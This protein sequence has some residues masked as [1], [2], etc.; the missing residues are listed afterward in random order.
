MAFPEFDPGKKKLLFFSRGRGRGHAIPDIEIVR[1]LAELR[2]DIDLRFVSYSTGART[3]E[4]AGYKLI[5]LA[6]PEGG[7]AAEMTAVSGKLIGWLKP[8]LVVSHEE[9]APLPVAKIFN[10]RTAFVIDWFIEADTYAMHCLKFADE[11]LFLQRQGLHDEPPY[12]NGKVNYFGRMRR[13]FEYTRED[14]PACRAQLGLEAGDLVIGVIPGR[15]ATESRAPIADLLIPAFDAL[16]HT[17]KHLVW[18]AGADFDTL[19]EKLSDR[20]DVT[21]LRGVTPPERLMAASDLVVAKA[22]TGSILEVTS[23]GV[24]VVAITQGDDSVADKVLARSEGVLLLDRRDSDSRQLCSGI[25]QQASAS[26]EPVL[27]GED[28]AARVAA[29]ISELLTDR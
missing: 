1:E 14:R 27:E 20:S 11:I 15:F 9:F 8:D 21:V 18:L 5:D 4:E 25:E 29:R 26:L 12:L 2:D 7:A 10:R 23:L 24:P 16:K 3:L 28:V 17:R 19:T 13:K 6:L 22:N